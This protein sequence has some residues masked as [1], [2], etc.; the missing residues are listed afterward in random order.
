ML[1]NAPFRWTDP[2][3]WSS[4]MPDRRPE[5]EQ[6]SGVIERVSFHNDDSGG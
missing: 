6:S 2:T 3:M 4:A 1:A 5:T